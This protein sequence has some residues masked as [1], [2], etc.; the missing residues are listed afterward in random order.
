M[1][2]THELAKVLL[3]GPDVPVVV[4]GYSGGY[5]SPHV[6]GAVVRPDEGDGARGYEGLHSDVHSD[7]VR[8][9]DTACVLLG[10]EPYSEHS[11]ASLTHADALTA[12]EAAR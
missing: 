12:V 10:R 9:T 5:D 4:D 11:H 3:A 8:T 6:Q 2:T 1:M 7:D